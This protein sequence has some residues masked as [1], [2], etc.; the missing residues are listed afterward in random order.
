M[1]AEHVAS[2]TI[3]DNA[4]PFR[5]S[6]P[7]A[8]DQWLHDLGESEAKVG[9]IGGSVFFG[10]PV[11]EVVAGDHAYVVTPSRYTFKQKGRMLRETGYTAFTLVK[12][13][14][15]WKV[16]SWSWASPSAAAVK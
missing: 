11:D 12:Q 4:A 1:K 9:R 13:G 2:P 15:V 6:G 3:V 8:F 14:A 16:E 5:W 7:D 10:A